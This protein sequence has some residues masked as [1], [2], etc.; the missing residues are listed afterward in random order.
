MADL[1]SKR[2]LFSLSLPLFLYLPLLPLL[3]P[4]LSFCPSLCLRQAH[5]S[6]RRYAYNASSSS[7]DRRGTNRTRRRSKRRGATGSGSNQANA[8]EG[9]EE[10][11]EEEDGV[12]ICFNSPLGRKHLSFKF[13]FNVECRVCRVCRCRRQFPSHQAI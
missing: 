8:E 5:G 1:D 13:L 2:H 12:G 10:E 7:R 11:E 9:E 4:S 3:Q 6:S